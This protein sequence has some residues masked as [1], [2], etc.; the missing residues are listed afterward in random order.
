MPLQK[1][2]SYLLIYLDPGKAY[3]DDKFLSA[4]LDKSFHESVHHHHNIPLLHI[5]YGIFQARMFNNLLGAYTNF[6]KA[7]EKGIGLRIQFYVY[8]GRYN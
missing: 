5:T 6:R 4:F 8:L 7:V 3:Q 1:F 2:D